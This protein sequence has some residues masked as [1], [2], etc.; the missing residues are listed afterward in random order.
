M[1]ITQSP[2]DNGLTPNG[3]VG[4]ITSQTPQIKDRGYQLY[5]IQKGDTL[6]KLSS[7]FE[8]SL[9][10]LNKVNPGIDPYKLQLGQQ[11][12]V[13]KIDPKPVLSRTVAGW[14]PYW[15]QTQTL[16]SIENQ[17]DLFSTLSPFWY[18]VT[19]SGEIIKYPDAEDSVILSFAK[20]QG[21]KMVPLITN[22]F[23]SELISTV[24]NDPT[25]R[26]NHINNILN[27]LSQMNYDGIDINYE[28]LFV[29]DK[30]IFVVFLQE[31]K[32]A[33]NIIGKQ[34]VVTV[35]AK[36][37][38]KGFWSGSEA[39][40][41]VGIGQTAD[42]VRIM[43][44]D[45]HW[46]GAGPGPI[47]PADWVNGVLAYAVSTIPKSKVVLGMPTYGYDWPLGQVGKGITYNYAISIANTFNVPIL[48]DAQLGPH[49]TYSINNISHEVW[50]SD[51]NSLATLLDLVNQYD[52]N[53]IC[54]W[55]LGAEDPKIY[56]TIRTKF[57]TSSS[58]TT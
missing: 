4:P 13:Q 15:L 52:I 46:L 16:R 39:H 49:F 28:N 37:N 31:L 25:I 8:M 38:S 36:T 42:A 22:A 48:E 26:R 14:I 11:I 3:D 56:S 53:G 17:S 40:D 12:W 45:F 29:S 2:K 47:A 43:A 23:S 50:F 10:D 9:N 44:Y 41:Y 57:I 21:I 34:L 35:H 5:T 27:I 55:Y 6:Y 51:A 20:I 54:F 58:G 32:T 33:L 24:L 19:M 7:I 18:E 1:A 30:E